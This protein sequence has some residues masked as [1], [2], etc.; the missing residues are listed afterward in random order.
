VALNSTTATSY[1]LLSDPH[2][3]GT[4][5]AGTRYEARAWIRSETPGKTVCLR[6][7]EWSAGAAVGGAER[8]R[9]ATG[10]WE[11]LDAVPYTAV[12]GD[13][14]ELYAYQSSAAAGDSFDIDGITLTAP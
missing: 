13:S 2:P 3:V 7:R 12:G 14:I 1:S 10:A 11:R 8:C 9:V 5:A 4:H 6:I